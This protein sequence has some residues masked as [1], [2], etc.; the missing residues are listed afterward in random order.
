M[1]TPPY[2]SINLRSGMEVHA[3][4]NADLIFLACATQA[5][6]AASAAPVNTM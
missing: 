5:Q 2:F 4:V 1:G 3:G 6:K